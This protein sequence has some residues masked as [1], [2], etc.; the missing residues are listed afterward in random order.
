V[1]R[2]KK[3]PQAT[4][5]GVQDRH[6][7][8]PLR[9]PHDVDGAGVPA[10][11][12]HHEAAPPYVGDEGLIVNYQRVVLPFRAGPLLVGSGHTALELSG[13]VH[14]SGDQDAAVHEQ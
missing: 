14:L 4:E 2:V 11:G 5:Q 12:Q 13:P 3:S 6:G 9:V 8:E 1:C 7:G 10:A